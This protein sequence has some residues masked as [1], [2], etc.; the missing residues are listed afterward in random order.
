MSAILTVK[1][2]STELGCLSLEQGMNFIKKQKNLK[3]ENQYFP[4]QIIYK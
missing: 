4:M 3:L 1:L 2:V